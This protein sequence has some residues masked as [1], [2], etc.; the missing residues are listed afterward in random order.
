M[1]LFCAWLR[2]CKHF[3]FFAKCSPS[4]KMTFDV[5]AFVS[6]TCEYCK[7][8]PSTKMRALSLHMKLDFAIKLFDATIPSKHCNCQHRLSNIWLQEEETLLV[9]TPA[10]LSQSACPSGIISSTPHLCSSP[11][12][13]EVNLTQCCLKHSSWLCSCTPS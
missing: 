11:I 13:E 5:D 4:P 1:R 9:D 6:K 8:Y 2:V 3:L 7:A 10:F 12:A